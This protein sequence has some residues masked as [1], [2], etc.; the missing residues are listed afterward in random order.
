M[1]MIFYVL[2]DAAMGYRE[3]FFRE[4]IQEFQDMMTVQASE[5][6][7]TPSEFRKKSQKTKGVALDFKHNEEQFNKLVYG[8]VEKLVKQF[9]PEQ[10]NVFENMKVVFG[11]MAEEIVSSKDRTK[12]LTVAKV[13]NSGQLDYLFEKVET[14][15]EGPEEVKEQKHSET[16]AD[17]D[18]LRVEN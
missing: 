4:D 6:S 14:Q 9:S 7:A 13:Y 11:L 3:G 10:M 1:R 12:L 18:H 16:V 5:H 17:G 8:H 2:I 15:Q